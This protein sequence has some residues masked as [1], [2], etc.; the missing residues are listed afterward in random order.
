[1]KH[2]HMLWSQVMALN[3]SVVHG[4]CGIDI[5]MVQPSVGQRRR[6]V[7]PHRST[8]RLEEAQQHFPQ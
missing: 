5:Q 6:Q 4:I 1:M 2:F 3:E 8:A 7:C